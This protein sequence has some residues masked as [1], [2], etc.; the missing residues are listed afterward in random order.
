M[1]SYNAIREL[2]KMWTSTTHENTHPINSFLTS[3]DMTKISTNYIK[4]KEFSLGRLKEIRCV[5]LLTCN[6]NDAFSYFHVPELF[7]SFRLQYQR[8]KA[9]DLDQVCNSLMV[10]YSVLLHLDRRNSL[11]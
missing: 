4:S 10:L 1:Y 2:G 9:I 6:L 11:P 3:K 5:I 8:S 7:C